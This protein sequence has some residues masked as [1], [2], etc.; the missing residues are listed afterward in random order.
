MKDV[1]VQVWDVFVRVCHW[2]LA[3]TVI[4]D[5]FADRPLWLHVWLGYIAGAVV[6]LRVV[7]GFIGPENARFA[8][9]VHGPRIVFDYL[10]GL[11]RFSSPRY[12]G[13]SPAGGAMIVALLLMVTATIGTGMANLAVDQG[14]GPLAR[15]LSK[16]EQPARV[17]GQRRPPLLI[18]EVHETLGN[19]T[20]VLIILHVLGVA[21]AS[22]VH[23]E[24]LVLAMVTGRKRALQE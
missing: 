22:L 23:R 15:I 5:W 14:E 17:P 21:L 20:L 24:N 11:A 6:V 13:H 2:L 8:S 4:V 12:L 1:E 10:I 19:I 7:W 16:V 3:T 18:R 9:F